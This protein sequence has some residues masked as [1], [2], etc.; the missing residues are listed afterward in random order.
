LAVGR[1]DVQKGLIDLLAAAEMVISENRDW[2]L[3]LAGDGPCRNWLLEQIATRPTLNG[4]VHWLGSRDDVPGLLQ[5]SDVFVIASLWEGMPNAVLEAMA[6]GRAVVATAVEGTEEVVVP[7]LTGWLVPPGNQEA[8]RQS[9]LAASSN[10]ALCH[11]YGQN[12]RAR[13]TSEFSLAKAVQ[14]YERL[15]CSV[16]GYKKPLDSQEVDAIIQP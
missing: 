1:L 4:H 9:L 2:H 6:A 8:L 11:D 7:G 3:A 10:P 13:I 12:A 14:A 16:L 5:S 15:W